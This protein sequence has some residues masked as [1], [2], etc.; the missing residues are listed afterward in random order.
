M[1]KGKFILDNCTP[2]EIHLANMYYEMHEYIHVS[3]HRYFVATTRHIPRS[4]PNIHIPH[5]QM[6]H[7]HFLIVNSYIYP[8]LHKSTFTSLAS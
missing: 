2:M 5:M 3:Q 1:I 8:K 4:P 6:Q 7:N